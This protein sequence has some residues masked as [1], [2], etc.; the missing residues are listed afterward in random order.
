ML[1]CKIPWP[2]GQ[3]NRVIPK[4][5]SC[6]I[7]FARPH[8]SS[9]IHANT[10]DDVKTTTIAICEFQSEQRTIQNQAVFNGN[11]HRLALITNMNV[12]KLV[13]AIVAKI[14]GA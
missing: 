6:D 4:R 1:N 10:L 3:R 11:Y 2:T 12:W 5:L 13:A 8:D 7:S 14:V 9:M